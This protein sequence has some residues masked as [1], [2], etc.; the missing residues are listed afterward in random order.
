MD[1]V[2]THVH[3]CPIVPDVLTRQHEHRSVLLWSRDHEMY[4]TNLQCRRF[5]RNLFQSYS[6]AP[7]KLVKKEPLEAWILRSFTGSETDDDLIL[8]TLCTT[9]LGGAQQRGGALV[10][11]Q[12]WAWSRIPALQP[13]L[14]TDVQDDPLAPLGAIWCTLGL[15]P[16]TQSHP[17]TSYAPP[18]LGLGFSSFQ[19][20]HPPSIGSS[21]FQAPPS[22]YTV[23]SST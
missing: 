8:G 12:S 3:Q 4:F 18:P 6:I 10:I 22:P 23:G 11:L 17:P 16:P 21:S 15:T 20:P 9:T 1:E 5:G 19:S 2:P 13:Q 7:R 14:M